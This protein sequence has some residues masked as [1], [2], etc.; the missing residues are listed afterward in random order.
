MIRINRAQ[1]LQYPTNIASGNNDYFQ[2]GI[3]SYDPPGIG[4]KPGGQ[5]FQRARS[6][7]DRSNELLGTYLGQIILP[8]PNNI[9]D[10]NSVTWDTDSINSIT[11]ATIDTLE[12]TIDELKINNLIDDPLASAGAA[13]N[14]L[15]QGLT[16]GLDAV[17]DPKIANVLKTALVGQ[18]VNIFGANVSLDTLASRTTG[19]VLNPNL[20]LLF[21]GVILR[22]FNYNFTLSPRSREE[23][24]EVKG[25]INTFKKRMAAK[26]TSGDGAGLFIKAP[27]VFQLKF[28][29][30]GDDHP[31][32]YK[33]KQCALTSMNVT[34]DSAGAYATYT[35]GTPVKMT[36]QLSFRELSPVYNEDYDQDLPGSNEGVGF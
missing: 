10:T 18:A 24:L 11:A 15:K 2:V 21:K 27:D 20:E 13:G 12:G 23:G 16:S 30:G 7:S 35:D 22:Q 5:F 3:F 17:K 8:M 29:Q 31:F 9:S 4:Q 14:A 1:L 34:Y 19:Q 28:K 33:I 6:L 36:L 25:I 26:T 32:L